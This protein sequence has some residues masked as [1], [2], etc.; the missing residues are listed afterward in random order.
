MVWVAV[1]RITVD[2]SKEADEVIERFAHRPKK[3][4]SSPGFLSL[5]VWR[6]EE[7]KEVLVMTRW[8]R[9][10]DFL[11]WVES[12]SF[13]QAHRGARGSPGEAHGAVYEVVQ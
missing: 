3:V 10:E 5:E 9:K 11:A 1:N 2:S 8:Q 6:E 4:D 13:R 12:P 7:G